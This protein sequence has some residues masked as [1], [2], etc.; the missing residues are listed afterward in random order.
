MPPEES[1]DGLLI[2]CIDLEPDRAAR[3]DQVFQRSTKF[4]YR[5]TLQTEF[6]EMLS[7]LF[8][9]EGVSARSTRYWP[10]WTYQPNITAAMT[11]RLNQL[12]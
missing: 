11:R 7:D 4:A 3:G 6:D 12:P 10:T 5:V 9:V 8:G 1:Q 2:K